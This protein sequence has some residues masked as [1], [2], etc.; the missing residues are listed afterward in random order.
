[1][2]AY[3]THGKPSIILHG[4]KKAIKNPETRLLALFLTLV[5][6]SGAHGQGPLDPIRQAKTGGNREQST[7][8]EA[9]RRAIYPQFIQE[10]DVIGFDIYPIYGSG[11]AAHLDWVGKGVSELRDL[12]RGRPVY[13]WIETGKGSKWMSY[14]KQPDVLP[15]HTRNEVWQ[16]IINDAMAIGYF[17]HAW[18]PGFKEFAPTADMQAELKRLNTQLTRLAPA[19]LAAPS[20]RKIE[21]KLGEGLNGQFK[22]TE[23]KDHIYIFSLNMDL[24]PEAEEA[25]QFDPIHPRNGKAVFLVAGLKAGMKI[26]VVDENRIIIA[27]KEKFT[28]EFAP[29]A[30]HIYKLSK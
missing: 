16:A 22:A 28:D 27:E 20:K 13:A 18:F 14:E 15:I 9:F 19:I 7:C 23:T 5:I 30:E 6:A 2:T 24:G 3:D 12:A 26:D 10:T 11:Y 17:T 8:P 29:L 25:K 4:Q 1:M 21:M